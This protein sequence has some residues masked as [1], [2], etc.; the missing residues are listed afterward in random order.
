MSDARR[1]HEL[2]E[3]AKNRLCHCDV[4]VYDLLQEASE[5]LSKW[6]DVKPSAKPKQVGDELQPTEK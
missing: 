2:V 3:N 5:L 1:V 4:A 6:T